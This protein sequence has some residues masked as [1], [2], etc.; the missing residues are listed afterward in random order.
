MTGQM[1]HVLQ[2]KESDASIPVEVKEKYCNKP[3]A[4]VAS[5]EKHLLFLA[6]RGAFSK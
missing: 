4:R 1:L 3:W 6:I 2:A 5:F